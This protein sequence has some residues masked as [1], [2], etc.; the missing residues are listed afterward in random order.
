M[1]SAL[2]RLSPVNPTRS[3]PVDF[4]GYVSQRSRHRDKHMIDGCPNYSFATDNRL[5]RKLAAVGP[6][7]VLARL[8]VRAREPY[9][10]QLLLMKAIAVGPNQLPHIFALGQQC[11]RRLG[12]GLPRI[13]V[14]PSEELNAYTLASDDCAPSIVITTRLVRALAPDELLAV[15]GHECGHIHN[16]HSAYN[17]LVV[18]MS[19]AGAGAVLN[20]ALRGGAPT[21]LLQQLVGL[22]GMGLRFFLLRWS[23]CAE[24]TS[25]RAGAIC[26]GSV[27]A[28]IRALIKL[29][30]GG[31]V[32]LAEIDVDT[33]VRQLDAIQGS[34]VRL[35]ELTASHPLI[36]KRI[37]AL[38]LFHNSQTWLDWCPE[39]RADGPVR[40]RDEV[41]KLCE[42]LI[43][44]LNRSRS[45]T[46]GELAYGISR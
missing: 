3:V 13:F 23:R 24:V 7:R 2:V 17:S 12:I 4:R 34:V 38:R 9:I 42:R 28:M 27:S 21:V 11:A 14:Q 41:D 31:E 18:L 1:T 30:I 8:L 10:Q 32:E 22:A 46:E 16:L 36:Q 43:G 37:E 5:R 29:Q 40:N 33:Y 44:V 35:T 6:M 26:A 19:N 39:L 20:A 25:D 15:I 45:F